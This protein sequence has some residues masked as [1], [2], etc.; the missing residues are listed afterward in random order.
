MNLRTLIKGIGA[1]L[2]F[3]ATGTVFN[4]N[5]P[6]FFAMKRW[7]S[8]E[9]RFYTLR[10][11]ATID[12]GGGAWDCVLIRAD[13]SKLRFDKTTSDTLWIGRMRTET[14]R[15]KEWDEELLEYGEWEYYTIET[16]IGEPWLTMH[17]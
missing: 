11:G 8:D 16:Q 14:R 6:V 12:A 9:V 13:G 1:A 17:T 10:P 2:A 4:P 5:A 15:H 7:N 3:A